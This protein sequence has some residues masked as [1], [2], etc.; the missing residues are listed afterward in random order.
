[1]VPLHITIFGHSPPRISDSIAANLKGIA[2][3]YIEAE[4][5]YFRVFGATVP[6]FALPLFILDNLACREIAR[7]TVIGG[8]SKDLKASSKKV[9]T[10][11]PVWLNS[12]SLL[13][14]RHA[15]AEAA[16][17]EDLS[18]VSIEYKRHDPQKIASAHLSNCGLKNFEHE[19]SPLDDIFRGA[20]SY[21]EVI[22][23]I[24]SLAPE[25][26]AS[27]LKFQEHRK[28]CL[29]AVLGG[30]G[31]SKDKEKEVESSEGQTSNPEKPQEG[32]QEKNSEQ[33]KNPKTEKETTDPTK[34]HSP[35][36]EVRNTYSPET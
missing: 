5:S 25:D 8:V 21:G 24:R 14:F 33:E 34:E 7:K 2:D 11:F 26:M 16:T 30:L 22:V 12:Y 29:P 36:V 9:W 15:K 23:R 19:C 28:I 6:P 20:R 31:L 35:E 4:F 13:D 27:V 32:E 3:W 10:F 17:L 18:L 1:M